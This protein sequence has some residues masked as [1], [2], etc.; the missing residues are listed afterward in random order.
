[1][2]TA[3]IIYYTVVFYTLYTIII[4]FLSYQSFFLS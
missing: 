4:I 2:I 1:M 3:L